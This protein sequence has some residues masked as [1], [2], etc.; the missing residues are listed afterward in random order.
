MPEPWRVERIYSND[1]EVC[2]RIMEGR[3]IVAEVHGAPYLGFTETLP[4]AYLLAAAPELL[5]TLD[6]LL[7]LISVNGPDVGIISDPHT[8]RTIHKARAAI[9]KATKEPTT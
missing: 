8:I 2:P 3:K 9:A 1:C 5:D 6:L 4:R 7:C